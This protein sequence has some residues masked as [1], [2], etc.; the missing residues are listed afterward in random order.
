MMSLITVT[1]GPVLIAGSIFNFMKSNGVNE[2]IKVAVATANM[3]P[4]PTVTPNAGEVFSRGSARN[5]MNTPQIVPKIMPLESP[6]FISLFRTLLK[7]SLW[8]SPVARPR[9]MTV[10]P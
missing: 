7:L 4:K 6:T 9:T 1:M 5:V 10:A 8:I 2:P 3:I